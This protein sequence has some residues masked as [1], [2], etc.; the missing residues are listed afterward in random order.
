MASRAPQFKRMHFCFH[1]MKVGFKYYRPLISLDGC[2]LSGHTKG[3][4]LTAIGIKANN[5]GY[6][7]AYTIV[8]E[9]ETY[10]SWSWFM[11]HLRDD[12]GG[13]Q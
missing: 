13:G 9:G 1:A 4:L 2:H 3:I 10:K 8:L 12:L 5:C 6:L 11:E 7:T